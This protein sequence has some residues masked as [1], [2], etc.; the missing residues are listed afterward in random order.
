MGNY[1]NAISFNISS[2]SC[3]LLDLELLVGYP[4]N[5]FLLFM[6][7]RLNLLRTYVEPLDHTPILS[8]FISILAAD[9][10]TLVIWDKVFIMNVFSKI[11]INRV[12]NCEVVSVF[13]YIWNTRWAFARKHDIFTSE[14][15]MLSSHVKRS[16][17]LWLHIKR[18][19]R[20]ESEMVWYFIGVYIINRT[21]HCRLEI[22]NFSSRFSTL[23][24][25]FRIS[26]RPCNILYIIILVCSLF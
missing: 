25:T 11:I 24:E 20:S 9:V 10:P 5:V 8:Y 7:W 6:F 4:F 19:F 3:Q 18:A 26:A 13:Y 22:G 2:K 1:R 17:L 15:N 14:N 12:R 23:E 16:P 21:L